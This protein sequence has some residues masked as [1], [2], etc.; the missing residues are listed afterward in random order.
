MS[1][2]R[3]K[4]HSVPFQAL[5]KSYRRDHVFHN[6]SDIINKKQ[7]LKKEVRKQSSD[8]SDSQLDK[9]SDIKSDTSNKLKNLFN[10]KTSVEEELN[11]NFKRK[12]SDFEK[13]DKNSGDFSL[14]FLNNTTK[15]NSGINMDSNTFR[16]NSTQRSHNNKNKYISHAGYNSFQDVICSK[17]TLRVL[18]II[19]IFL[20]LL[21]LYTIK[22]FQFDKE[23]RKNLD[24]LRENA[25]LLATVGDS[26]NK[27]EE[28]NLKPI[29]NNEV[30]IKIKNNASIDNDGNEIVISEIKKEKEK[31]ISSKKN[32]QSVTDI[33][34]PIS[35]LAL[36]L[37]NLE[38]EQAKILK[39]YNDESSLNTKRND[40][41]IKQVKE[42]EA[43]IINRTEALL[44]SYLFDTSNVQFSIL[45]NIEKS[46][47]KNRWVF[48]CNYDEVGN[49][50]FASQNVSIVTLL[51]NLKPEKNKNR[52]KYRMVQVGSCSLNILNDTL[53]SISDKIEKYYIVD[54]VLNPK[55]KS[56]T[57]KL[58]NGYSPI[59]GSSFKNHIEAIQKQYPKVKIQAGTKEINEF[60]AKSIDIIFL[61]SQPTASSL[62]KMNIKLWFDKIR[63]DG[64]L[65]GHSYGVMKPGTKNSEKT[66]KV[67]WLPKE[68][69]EE[70]GKI[71]RLV[72]SS[73][74]QIVDSFLFSVKEKSDRIV[75]LA[76]DT[77]WYIYKRK[78]SLANVFDL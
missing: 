43:S 67:S 55:S 6:S 28:N 62:K 60:E 44:N 4:S 11:Y 31:N 57:S 52:K 47:G 29:N 5:E 50:R 30:D 41:L 64:V 48:P 39:L 15:D 70:H 35:L 59:S 36:K 42:R 3:K 58:C 25:E 38:K 16:F 65:I 33:K 68:D 66:V 74:K 75:Q 14:L 34:K 13:L 9:V 73:T 18:L 61:D 69:V 45:E 22:N 20:F 17:S 51:K 2:H 40:D 49:C 71:S 72:L 32:N 78:V 1:F 19:F 26:L 8:S 10:S 12:N 23:T 37:E 24:L 21:Q 27:I 54:P 53:S 7:I 77:V 63:N 76:G 56:F 46:S